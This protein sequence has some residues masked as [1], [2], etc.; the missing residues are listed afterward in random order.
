MHPV[1][2]G[3][4]GVDPQ[5]LVEQLLGV[6]RRKAGFDIDGL[7]V[8]E[9]VNLLVV[10]AGGGDVG[11]VVVVGE[12]VSGEIDDEVAVA[13]LRDGNL[14][15]PFDALHLDVLHLGVANQLHLTG[16]DAEGSG[17]VLGQ[18]FTVVVGVGY[19]G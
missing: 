3:A 19:V 16:G 4:E 10:D 5:A 11:V 2:P 7:F 8:L 9:G 15:H 12:S 1:E 6:A 14:L 18:H 17:A 13:F